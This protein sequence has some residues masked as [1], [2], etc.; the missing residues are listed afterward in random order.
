MNRTEFVN[1]L[2]KKLNVSKTQSDKCLSAVLDT[3]TE[4]ITTEGGIRFVGFGSFT[5]S[6]RSARTATNPRDPSQKIDVPERYIPVFRPSNNLK[7]LCK[8]FKK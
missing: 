4:N 6:Y 5:V 1:A 7:S 3:I 2:A 8:D